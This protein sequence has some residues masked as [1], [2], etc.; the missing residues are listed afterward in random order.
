MVWLDMINMKLL[1]EA[2]TLKAHMLAFLLDNSDGHDMSV[3]YEVTGVERRMDRRDDPAW[4]NALARATRALPLQESN[5][6][7]NT[8]AGTSGWPSRGE[9]LGLQARSN[10]YL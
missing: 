6:I 3:A 10:R 2:W 5:S 9:R 4:E 8:L 1:A 7:R